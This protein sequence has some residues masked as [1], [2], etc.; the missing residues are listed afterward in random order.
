MAGWVRPVLGVER[1]VP[2]LSPVEEV[3]RDHGQRQTSTRVFPRDGKQFLL[4]LVP[5][6]RLPEP[7][8]PLRH[9]WD[10]AGRQRIRLDDVRGSVARGDPVVEL[11]GDVHVPFGDVLRERHPT[12]RRV[13]PE[14]AIAE[15]RNGEGDAR[16]RVALGELE[17]A[18][19]EIEELVLVLAHA[20]DLLALV[21]LEPDGH[22]VFTAEQGAELATADLERATRWVGR[23]STTNVLAQERGPMPVDE[24]DPPVVRD[25]R[26]DPA[27][28]DRGAPFADRDASARV[29]RGQEGPILCLHRGPMR[30]ANTQAVR[31]PRLDPEL[32]GT[33]SPDQSRP[34][35]LE[36]ALHPFTPSKRSTPGT[37]AGASPVW[38]T[39]MANR[40][41]PR[42]AGSGCCARAEVTHN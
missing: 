40:P 41:P 33:K 2:L 37:A 26:L 23:V 17:R 8:R 36:D 3:G 30:H 24:V 31:A 39:S 7:R 5:Q 28:A 34:I 11:P 42:S 1:P 32:F 16:L 38:P 19:L 27:V 35:L 29:G 10:R 4:R 20:E 14:E 9:Q 25:D 6:L 22:L 15:A 18:A 12:D 21:R 13:V